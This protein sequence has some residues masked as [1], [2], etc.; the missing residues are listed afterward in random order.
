MSFGNCYSTSTFRMTSGMSGIDRG[1][2]SRPFRAWGVLM[3]GFQGYSRLGSF[4][5]RCVVTPRWGWDLQLIRGKTVN[6]EH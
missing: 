3:D 4:A 6:H 2:L 5:L 1:W